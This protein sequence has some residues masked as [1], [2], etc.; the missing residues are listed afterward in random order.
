M[1]EWLLLLCPSPAHWP[2]SGSKGALEIDRV[3]EQQLYARDETSPGWCMADPAKVTAGV[4]RLT[5]EC[6][7]GFDGAFGLFSETPVRTFC[8][9]QCTGPSHGACHN[10]A[11]VVSGRR[12]A[13]LNV[14]SL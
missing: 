7:N 6:Y 11:C 10:G 1:R 9:G 4:Q 2:F 3:D 14:I 12:S 13:P 5:R 8:I